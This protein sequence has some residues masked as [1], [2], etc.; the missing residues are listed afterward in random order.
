MKQQGKGQPRSQGSLL[1]ALR[2]ERERDPWER[3]WEKAVIFQYLLGTDRLLR[4]G[5]VQ[6]LKRFNFGGSVL[7]M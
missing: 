1:P 7:K 2:S 3:G 6:F 4:S 5:G